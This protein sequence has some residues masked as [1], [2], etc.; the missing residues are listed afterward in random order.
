MCACEVI[1]CLLVPLV[2]LLV[3]AVLAAIAGKSI[4]VDDTAQRIATLSPTSIPT[5]RFMGSRKDSPNPHREDRALHPNR[6]VG[7]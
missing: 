3:G 4:G 2:D 1:F 5:K 6:L 7:C